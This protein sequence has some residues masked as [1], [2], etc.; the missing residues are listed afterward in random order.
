MAV[1]LLTVREC[2]HCDNSGWLYPHQVGDYITD[3]RYA[4]DKCANKRSAA[5]EI[6]YLRDLNITLCN[7]HMWSNWVDNIICIILGIVIGVCSA[8]LLW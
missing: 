5:D 2:H 7:T 3:Q 6:Q 1:D 4:C 8:A